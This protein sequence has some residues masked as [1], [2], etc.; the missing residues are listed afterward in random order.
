MTR[1]EAILKGLCRADTEVTDA[2]NQKWLEENGFRPFFETRQTWVTSV[3]EMDF[4]L[5][6][7]IKELAN[8]W[9]LVATLQDGKWSAAI[10]GDGVGKWLDINTFTARSPRAENAVNMA[11]AIF[12]QFTRDLEKAMR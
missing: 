8:G 1:N 12:N 3:N 4:L 6:T 11:L 9:R 2:A 10:T 5:N 7:W